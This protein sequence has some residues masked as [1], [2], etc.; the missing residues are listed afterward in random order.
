M[1]TKGTGMDRPTVAPVEAAAPVATV[2][3]TAVLMVEPTVARAVA[4]TAART[5]VPVET[6]VPMV[7]PTVARTAVPAAEHLG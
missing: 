4:E 5:V 7:E 1:D 3:Q 2:V 6:V